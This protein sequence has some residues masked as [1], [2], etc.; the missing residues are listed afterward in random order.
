MGAIVAFGW[1]ETK[2]V[3]IDLCL[4]VRSQVVVTDDDTIPRPA[5]GNLFPD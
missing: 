1:P 2:G 4:N 5:N 3:F